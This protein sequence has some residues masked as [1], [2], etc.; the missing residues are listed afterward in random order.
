MLRPTGERPL[1]A[2]LGVVARRGRSPLPEQQQTPQR[3]RSSRR[4]RTLWGLD[5]H[6]APPAELA[7]CRVH[8]SH[9]APAAL[10]I[11]WSA[12]WLLHDPFH[13]HLNSGPEWFKS[14]SHLEPSAL[15]AQ[16]IVG[17]N[18][19]R[20]SIGLAGFAA[21]EVC[22]KAHNGTPADH[23]V[24]GRCR[25]SAIISALAPEYHGCCPSFPASFP[26]LGPPKALSRCRPLAR[27]RV[28]PT[29]G[30]F[31]AGLLQRT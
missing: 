11:I 24:E 19:D 31:V 4:R 21:L 12:F 14:L 30:A 26:A 1:P 2:L 3:R 8:S 25:L 29:P 28:C 13:P 23:R 18:H 22:L 27:D 5:T 20:H 7:F 10:G 15:P 16:N 9:W 17:F 6:L